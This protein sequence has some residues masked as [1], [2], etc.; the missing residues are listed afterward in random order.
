MEADRGVPE[1]GNAWKRIETD[2]EPAA[3]MSEADAV[4]ALPGATMRE[5]N[6]TREWNQPGVLSQGMA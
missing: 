5:L 4:W 2:Q 6:A 1:A 3:L